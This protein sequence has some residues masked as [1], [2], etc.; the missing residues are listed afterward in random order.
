LNAQQN[1]KFQNNKEVIEFQ[2]STEK[3]LVK[4]KGEDSRIIQKLT[5]NQFTE[6][7]ENTAIIR[8]SPVPLV[9][10]I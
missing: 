3:F 9:N 7:S 6:I 2:I 4:F 1:L 8:T 5:D 10:R